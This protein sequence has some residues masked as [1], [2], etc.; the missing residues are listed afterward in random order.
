[1]NSKEVVIA[2]MKA[3]LEKKYGEVDFVE[4][5]YRPVQLTQSYDEL[6]A[7]PPGGDSKA[8]Q[9]VVLRLKGDE[10]TY[11]LDDYYGL[12]VREE[13]E[14]LVTETASDFL[15]PVKVCASFLE[16][17][18]PRD[19]TAA[20][21]LKDVLDAE[22]L[23]WALVDVFVAGTEGDVAEFEKQAKVFTDEWSQRYP[24]TVLGIRVTL[25]PPEAYETLVREN[26]TD[27]YAQKNYL[28]DIFGGNSTEDV[29]Q[30]T[31]S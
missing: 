18:F 4:L 13:Y 14:Q 19:V 27:I 25:I 26:H 20:T 7:C 28:S 30:A 8:D 23:T 31:T 2:Q 3:H 5:S 21:P 22:E 29:K 6:I 1:M 16:T 17:S 10:G 24:K 9:F 11:F 15:G 12:L